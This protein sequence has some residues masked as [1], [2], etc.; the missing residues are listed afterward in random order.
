MKR[1]S[2]ILKEERGEK[3]ASLQELYK[4]AEDENR[5]F[6]EDEQ[7]R[8]DSITQEIEFLD[9]EIDEVSAR[10]KKQDEWKSR[11]TKRHKVSSNRSVRGEKGEKTQLKANYSLVKAINSQLRNGVLDGVEAEMHQE[12]VK[13]ARGTAYEVAGVGIPSF[14][15]SSKRDLSDASTYGEEVI[16]TDTQPLIEYL[17]PQLLAE[18]LGAQVLQ[19]KGDAKF[20]RNDAVGSSAWEGEQDTT[21]ETTPTLDSFTLSPNRNAAYTE[22]S[23]QL[24]RQSTIGVENFVRNDLT[25]AIQEAVETAIYNGSGASNQP[26]GILNTSGIGDV[27]HGA[28]GGASTWAT[29]LEHQSKLEIANAVQGSI[30]W[31]GTPTTKSKHM[32][33]EKASNTAQFLMNDPGNA[34]LGYAYY[35]SNLMPTTLTKGTG[36][37]LHAQIFGNWAELFIG[38]FGGIDLLVDPYSRGKDAT[39]QIIANSYWDVGLRHPASFVASKDIDVS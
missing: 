17:R 18:Q 13:E 19:L 30:A 22:Y 12:A 16:S 27:S 37:S 7:T 31:V 32:Q 9:T 14:F 15:M 23:V 28:N 1:K 24:L 8:F 3:F 29:V 2:D 36:S 25:R 11:T 33:I 34:L 35:I 5:D 39:V 6:T 26:T 4:V 38:Q 10:E 20:P 21:A